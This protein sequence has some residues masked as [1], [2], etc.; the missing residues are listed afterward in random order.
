MNA[1]TSTGVDADLEFGARISNVSSIT[2]VGWC[3]G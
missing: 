2:W 1:N 3:S